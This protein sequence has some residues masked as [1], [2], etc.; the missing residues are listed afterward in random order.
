M[1]IVTWKDLQEELSLNIFPLPY[2]IHASQAFAN[3][4]QGPEESLT[5]YIQ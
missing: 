5:L 1:M 2:N 4:I 3:L